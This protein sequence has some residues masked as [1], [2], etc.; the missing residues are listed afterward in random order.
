MS[1]TF[2][3][4]IRIYRGGALG[5]FIVTLPVFKI[6]KT[7]FPDCCIN[8]VTRAT[9]AASLTLENGLI[10]QISSL[11]SP[12]NLFLFNKNY[13]ISENEKQELNAFDLVISYLPDSDGTIEQQL[14]KYCKNIVISQYPLTKERHIAEH[15]IQPLIQCGINACI[16]SA[17]VT[18]PPKKD[19]QKNGRAILR[20]VGLTKNP[21]II[22]PGS[23]SPKK[24]YPLKN[25]IEIYYAI[26]QRNVFEPC[27]L[28]G[29]AEIG[30][31]DSIKQARCRFIKDLTL[32]EVVCLL[33]AARGYI[34]N[35][36]GI[37]HLAAALS[38]PVFAI[39][40]ATSPL[41]WRP[42]GKKIKILYKH[43][44][45]ALQVLTS[46]CVYKKW[47]TFMKSYV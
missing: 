44:E 14:R 19:W 6:L 40:F 21:V 23:G 3:K 13:D 32:K 18:L 36:S 41:V 47:V 15:L 42:L 11:E 10:D 17:L 2:K 24:N 29:E 45:Q 20:D 5:D 9:A 31:E 1:G 27:F 16:D 22:H 34:G 39:F 28:L 33:A 4:R 46:E 8:V 35:D 30:M 37:T 12:E 26:E 7:T 25:F 38:I 43:S